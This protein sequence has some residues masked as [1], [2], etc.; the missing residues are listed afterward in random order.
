[1]PLAQPLQPLVEVERVD[2]HKQ[3]DGDHD[4]QQRHHPADVGHHPS[5]N[6]DHATRVDP[7]QLFGDLR[8]GDSVPAA[9][10]Q[11]L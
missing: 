6:T 7:L 4:H 9:Q 2:D 11:Q 1:M 10:T 8:A 3:Q 5:D